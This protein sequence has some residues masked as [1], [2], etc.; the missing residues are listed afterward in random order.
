[1]RKAALAVVHSFQIH[2]EQPHLGILQD[3]VSNI[4]GVE[5]GL[6]ARCNHVTKPDTSVISHGKGGEAEGTALGDV[7]HVSRKYAPALQRCGEGEGN[8]G[9]EIYHTLTVR[10][11]MRTPPSRAMARIRS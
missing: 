3:I 4:D 10:S 1:M 9:H 7:G 5:I 8:P 6:I 11:R 2:E